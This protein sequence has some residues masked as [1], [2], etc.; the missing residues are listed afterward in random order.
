MKEKQLTYWHYDW[1]GNIYQRTVDLSKKTKGDSY[2]VDGETE[3]YYEL[4]YNY[5]GGGALIKAYKTPQAANKAAIAHIK[6]QLSYH[7]SKL[8]EFIAG[9]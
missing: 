6:K 7:I 1:E 3:D 2:Y 5:G 4:L 8:N 9:M